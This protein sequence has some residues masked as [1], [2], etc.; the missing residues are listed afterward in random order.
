MLWTMQKTVIASHICFN[1]SQKAGH[2]REKEVYSISE[3]FL[4]VLGFCF[5]LLLCG[6]IPCSKLQWLRVIYVNG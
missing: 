5:S 1:E 3:E 6:D 4:V 2:R